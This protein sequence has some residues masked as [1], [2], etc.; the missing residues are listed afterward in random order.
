MRNSTAHFKWKVILNAYT[1]TREQRTLNLNSDHNNFAEMRKS[2]RAEGG[3]Q[4]QQQRFLNYCYYLFLHPR[5]LPCVSSFQL[6]CEQILC[7]VL[8]PSSTV[9]TVEVLFEWINTRDRANEANEWI[10]FFEKNINKKME[11]KIIPRSRKCRAYQPVSQWHTYAP[12]TSAQ[13]HF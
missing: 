8:F 10:F 12:Y 4:H 9:A 1:R 6:K 5:K 11:I 7:N 13:I 2:A 3:E